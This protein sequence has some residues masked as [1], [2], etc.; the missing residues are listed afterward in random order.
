MTYVQLFLDWDGTLTKHDTILTLSRI[1]YRVNERKGVETRPWIEIVQ[2]YLNDLKTYTS[3]YVPPKESRTK[4]ELESQYLASLK[5]IERSS[6]NRVA[7]AEVFAHVSAEDLHVGAKEALQSGG[8]GMRRGWEK[9]F[10]LAPDPKSSTRSSIDVAIVTVNWSAT[11]IW[12]CLSH[13]AQASGIDETFIRDLK[14][15]GNEVNSKLAESSMRATGVLG[16][17][18]MVHTSSDKATALRK[19]IANGEKKA[20]KLGQTYI[21]V[22][23]GDTATDFDALLQASV[24]V[25][26]RDEPL[27]GGQEELADTFERVGIEVLPLTDIDLSTLGP[28]T[29]YWTNDLSEVAALL[30]EK[31]VAS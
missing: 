21:S 6:T 24:G 3:S 7:K 1:G 4:I 16:S 25:C 14:I 22:Y 15:Y 18:S 19:A 2:A 29:V 8:V 30:S 9:L 17:S 10:P 12:S 31:I 23:V 20:A 26:V 13:A 5:D 27:R 28:K 11:F